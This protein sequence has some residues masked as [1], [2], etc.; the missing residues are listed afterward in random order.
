[1]VPRNSP[2]PALNMPLARCRPLSA[3]RSA[4]AT[5]ISHNRSEGPNC[6]A[7][8]AMVGAIRMTMMSDS[9]SAVTEE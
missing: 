5:T 4:M 9:V 8:S 3:P 6:S 1:M 2:I 7:I